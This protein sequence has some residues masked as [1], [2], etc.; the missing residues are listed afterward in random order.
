M[1]RMVE[2]LNVPAYVT[3]RRWDLLVWNDAATEVFTDFNL[4]PQQERNILL[5]ML[6]A[7]WMKHL[8]GKAWADEAKRMIALFRTTYDLWAGDPEFVELLDRIRQASSEFQDGGTHTMLAAG[9][10][11]GKTFTIRGRACLA[12]RLQRSNRTTTRR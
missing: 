5:H 4:I 10:E 6:T 3:G 8:F 2:R 11:F 12:S 7:P 9:P 1:Q